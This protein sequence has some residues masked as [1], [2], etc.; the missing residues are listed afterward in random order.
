MAYREP[1]PGSRFEG[2]GKCSRCG[3][4]IYHGQ[5]W[6][7][8]SWPVPGTGERAS[9][10]VCDDCARILDDQR[11]S[12]LRLFG[13]PEEYVQAVG[14][15]LFFGAIVVGLILYAILRLTGQIVPST[16]H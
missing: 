10:P 9:G 7:M 11:N 5:P 4:T 13:V 6:S 15:A 2:E 16:Y 12:V 14:A 3:W 8:R 1:L